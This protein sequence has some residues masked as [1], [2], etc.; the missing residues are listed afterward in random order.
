MAELQRAS[1]LKNHPRDPLM[2]SPVQETPKKQARVEDPAMD[3]SD[4]QE[5]VE[6]QG[7]T[8]MAGQNDD[9]SLAPVPAMPFPATQVESPPGLSGRS[10][11]YGFGGW[12]VCPGSPRWS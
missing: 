5:G 8:Q 9:S 1:A 4:E 11:W 6:T 3:L 7:L 2:G 10:S 12:H